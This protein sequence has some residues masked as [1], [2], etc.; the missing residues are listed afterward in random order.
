MVEF[1]LIIV[2]MFVT[3]GA[4]ELAVTK[5]NSPNQP[6]RSTSVDTP[7]EFAILE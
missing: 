1:V 7:S 5:R 4:I 3:A 6:Q 2:G